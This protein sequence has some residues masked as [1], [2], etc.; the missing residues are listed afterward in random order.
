MYKIN[1]Q[2]YYI[3]GEKATKQWYD[4]I[5]NPGHNFNY[6]NQPG[7]GHFTQVYLFNFKSFSCVKIIKMIKV[8]WKNST[9]VGFGVAE[10]SDGSFYAVANYYPGLIFLFLIILLFFIRLC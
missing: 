2:N 9:H 6:D 7:T 4:E 8:V 3:K 1:L 10:A 5:E